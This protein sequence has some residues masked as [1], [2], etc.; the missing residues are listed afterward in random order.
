MT[1]YKVQYFLRILVSAVVLG[2]LGGCALFAKAYATEVF[3]V[4]LIAMGAGCVLLALPILVLSVGALFRKQRR[5][6]ITLGAALV[7][8]ATGI[9]FMLFD[10]SSSV[11]SWFMLGCYTTALP[12]V[13]I[14]MAS[15]RRRQ[16][17]IELTK[18]L[19]GAFMFCITFAQNER[20]MCA[21][22]G[23]VLI[24]IAVLYL[25]TNLFR[26]KKRFAV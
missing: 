3:D 2:A 24:V 20:A 8:I 25:V 19:L 9:L 15:D 11:V 1:K 7:Q 17:G 4:L 21:I 16:L 12:A 6:W 22:F 13:Y 14:V 18:V 5:A 10:R 23:I 26:M